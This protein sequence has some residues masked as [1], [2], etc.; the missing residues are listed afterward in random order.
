VSAIVAEGRTLRGRTLLITGAT[1]GIGLAIGLRAARDGAHIVVLGKTETPHPKLPGTIHTAA[2]EIEAA[3]GRA[4]AVAC[5]VRDEAQIVAAIAHGV[6]AFGGLDIL[7]NNASAIALTGT[8]ATDAKRY[9][10][11]Q[12]VNARATFLC[13][14]HAIAHL[15][16]GNNPHILT[17]SPPVNL[18]PRWIGPHIAYTLSKYGMTLVTL[19]LAEE[20]RPDGIAA[21]CLWP[22]TTIATAAVS[23]HFGG[24]A[25]LARCR[26]PEIVAD[27]AHALLTRD[28]RHSTGRCWI[29]D[30]LLQA[31]GVTDLSC[32]AVDS[33]SDLV[34][35]LF[36]EPAG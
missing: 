9:D 4:L 14:K 27:A 5:D 33:N 26:K 24:A 21:N 1:R 25:A 13:A 35:D 34:T 17:M 15:R 7:V 2:A 19:G 6:A 28:S 8:E 36:L 16:R 32:Y 12:Q 23:T 20:L 11:L 30:E 10:L 31:E 18:A 3:G 29:D 22:R